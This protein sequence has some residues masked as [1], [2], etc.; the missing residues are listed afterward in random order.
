M[1]S[2][3]DKWMDLRKTLI[4]CGIKKTVLPEKCCKCF[5]CQPSI[6]CYDCGAVCRECDDAIHN[7]ISL[8]SRY[9]VVDN[10]I[11]P[12]TPL[13]HLSDDGCIISKSKTIL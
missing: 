6:F 9:V 12:L 4:E 1:E 13:Q 11:Y 5:Q 10:C 8:H 3:D 2:V 7:S